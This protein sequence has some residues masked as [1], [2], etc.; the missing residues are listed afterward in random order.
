MPVIRKATP[1]DVPVILRLVRELATYERE[2]DAVVAT[3]ADYLACGF[4]EEP[5]F[6]VLLAEEDGETIGFALWFYT[7]STWTGTR[8]V[9]LED[10]F[11]QPSHRGKGAG[12]SLM[13]AL[14]RAAVDAGCK[15]F[16]WN[17]LEWNKPAIDFYARLGAEILPDWRSVRL[18]GE[19]LTAFAS[20]ATR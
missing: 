1:A 12:V 10:L 16:V 13:R 14:A 20:D 6:E 15:R 18:D 7:F 8:C 11:V 17:V 5:A 19:A 9:H 3:E 4:G 2:P